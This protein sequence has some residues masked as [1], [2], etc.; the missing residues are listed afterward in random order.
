MKAK[1]VDGP[2][3]SVEARDSVSRGE[4]G[5]EGREAKE[6]QAISSDITY[7]PGSLN[8]LEAFIYNLRRLQH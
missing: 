4:V 3:G 8:P 5:S 7:H 6:G 1:A 2:P